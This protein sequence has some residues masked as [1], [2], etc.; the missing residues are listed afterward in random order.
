M[1]VS[2]FHIRLCKLCRSA[3]LSK[4]LD[5]YWKDTWVIARHVAVSTSGTRTLSD[6][7]DDSSF[8]RSTAQYNMYDANFNLH[9]SFSAS[10]FL[11]VSQYIQGL[12]SS[13]HFVRHP[14]CCPLAWNQLALSGLQAVPLKYPAS[15]P[16]LTFE[17]GTDTLLTAPR[18]IAMSGR[19]TDPSACS[20]A[21]S[22]PDFIEA[23]GLST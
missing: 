10:H 22:T 12:C 14:C 23:C 20:R 9:N 19:R 17:T 4:S 1:S 7:Y 2:H 16:A 13:I 3:F 15:S 21:L 18:S 6:T 5:A 11:T 8:L